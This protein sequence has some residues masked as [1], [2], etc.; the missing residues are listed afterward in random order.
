MCEVNASEE[1]K[2]DTRSTN[3]KTGCLYSEDDQFDQKERR[4][5]PCDVTKTNSY[6]QE[7]NVATITT[8]II[9]VW[10]QGWYN[11]QY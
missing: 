10:Y 11:Q 7:D 3:E 4:S 8:R 5:A 2:T 6:W 9:R 1:D